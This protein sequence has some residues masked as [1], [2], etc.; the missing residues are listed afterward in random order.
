[1][2]ILYYCVCVVGVCAVSHAGQ[3]GRSDSLGTEVPDNCE[4]PDLGTGDRTNVLWKIST[5]C[6][7]LSHLLASFTCRDKNR[8]PPHCTDHL[9][10]FV[11]TQLS[12]DK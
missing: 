4:R 6:E 11:V 12:V 3:K 5:C 10:T 1:M 7:P 9:S 8:S 2:F